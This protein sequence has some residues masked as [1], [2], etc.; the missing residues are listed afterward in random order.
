MYN[1]SF[2]D[3]DNININN[4]KKND[5]ITVY[6]IEH[7]IDIMFVTNYINS[8]DIDDIDDV[9][10]SDLVDD[11][12]DEYDNIFYSDLEDNYNMY[13]G[14]F[15]NNKCNIIII[16]KKFG[17]FNK[18]KVPILFDKLIIKPLILF[19]KFYNLT[20]VCVDN[21][22]NNTSY[23]VNLVNYV[24][25]INNYAILAGSF[26][27]K[28][29]YFNACFTQKVINNDYYY[30]ILLKNFCNKNMEYINTE[31]FN[32]FL[33]NCKCIEDSNNNI[34]TRYFYKFTNLFK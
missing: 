10:Y 33:V 24:Y 30:G 31:L 29:K 11:E 9:F 6:L 8:I 21:S 3:F 27:Y 28:I 32:S 13:K 7:N 1:C 26:N 23:N 17:S 12:Y 18:I 14:E 22:K 20:L 25:N 34:I 16:N 4:Y 15:Y 5:Y 19:S 2:I